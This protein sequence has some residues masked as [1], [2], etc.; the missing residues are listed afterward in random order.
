MTVPVLQTVEDQIVKI[1][2]VNQAKIFKNKSLKKLK[3]KDLKVQTS[4]NILIK[5]ISK[6]SIQCKVSTQWSPIM[7][8]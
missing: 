5:I 2:R 8:K 1:I 4:I 3:D 7:K 6:K